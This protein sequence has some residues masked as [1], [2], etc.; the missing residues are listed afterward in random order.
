VTGSLVRPNSVEELS[1]AIGAYI[2]NPERARVEGEA[3]RKRF[4]EHFEEGRYKAGVV[5]IVAGLSESRSRA[6]P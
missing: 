5:N 2:L 1:A 4:L 6:A 3:G